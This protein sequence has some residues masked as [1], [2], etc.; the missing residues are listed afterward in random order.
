METDPKIKEIMDRIA[1]N[2]EPAQNCPECGILVP[3]CSC[4]IWDCGF[5]ADHLGLDCPSERGIQYR[6]KI[7]NRKVKN[8][9]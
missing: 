7:K 4:G 2:P 1:N 6:E 3:T 9:I 8:G 5:Y